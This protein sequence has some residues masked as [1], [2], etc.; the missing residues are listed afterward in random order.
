VMDLN[1]GKEVEV[2]GDDHPTYLDPK[3]E[4]TEPKA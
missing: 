2:R 4:S 1:G 3:P